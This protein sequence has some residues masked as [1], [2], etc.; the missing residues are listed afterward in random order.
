MPGPKPQVNA[1]VT[2]DNGDKSQ[3]RVENLG[4]NEIK[5]TKDYQLDRGRL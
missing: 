5:I 4:K 1:F 3:E 2:L